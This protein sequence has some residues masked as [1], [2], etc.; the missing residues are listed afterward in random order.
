M[1]VGGGDSG[2]R[3][4]TLPLRFRQVAIDPMQVA[5]QFARAPIG[6][7][8]MLRCAKA[9]K[10]KALKPKARAVATD[11]AGLIKP[12]L[13]AIVERKDKS[14][15]IIGKISAEDAPVQ[16]P[17]DGRP[18]IIKRAEFEYDW[19][20]RIVRMARQASLSDLARRFDISWFLQAMY[21]CRRL[22]RE[23]LIASILRRAWRSR[24]RSRPGDAE[25]SNIRYR[26]GCCYKQERLRE[27]EKEMEIRYATCRA[28]NAFR[29]YAAGSW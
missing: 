23:V 20:G 1:E 11:W 6:V 15:I 19:A 21:K 29:R 27:V 7:P 25:P 22:L 14:F 10:L 9:L 18:L 8:E 4:L 28:L 17:S 13:P 12:P 16:L 3:C 26:C 24:S 5:H 2:A